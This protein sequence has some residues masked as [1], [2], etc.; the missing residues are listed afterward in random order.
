MHLKNRP[1]HYM[2]PFVVYV[3]VSRCGVWGSK[4]CNLVQVSLTFPAEQ[5]WGSHLPAAALLVP[6]G[7]D[8]RR[9]EVGQR[10]SRFLSAGALPGERLVEPHV[11]LL[12]RKSC[13]FLITTVDFAFPF[14]WFNIIIMA[15]PPQIPLYN[16]YPR[17]WHYV[18]LFAT[19]NPLE[20]AVVPSTF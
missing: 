8:C 10:S 5:Q 6:K 19:C 1:Q 2:V 20:K 3:L 13:F 4:K 18:L 15:F 9:E 14:I 17:N 11:L 16:G 7:T 12:S